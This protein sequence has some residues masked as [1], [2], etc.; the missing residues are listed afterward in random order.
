MY[1]PDYPF[2]FV[3]D[4]GAGLFYGDYVRIVCEHHHGP[5]DASFPGRGW[6]ALIEHYWEHECFYVRSDLVR[7]RSV[8]GRR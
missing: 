2:E 1:E 6:Y 7:L 5:E 3:G 4:D 8:E